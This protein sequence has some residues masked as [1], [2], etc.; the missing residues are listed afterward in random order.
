MRLVRKLWASPDVDDALRLPLHRSVGATTNVGGRRRDDVRSRP[1]HVEGEL[2]PEGSAGDRGRR[3]GGSEI[4]VEAA[5][6]TGSPGANN[7]GIG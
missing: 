5:D 4:H 6:F 2:V 1:L 3:S 7:P